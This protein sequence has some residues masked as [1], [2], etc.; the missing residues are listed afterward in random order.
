MPSAIEQAA[1]E[2]RRT[3]TADGKAEA[4]DWS[5][6]T[7]LVRELVWDLIAGCA[8]TPAAGYAYLTREFG[9]VERLLGAGR[10]RERRIRRAVA[11]HWHG[12]ADRL[13]E[14]EAAVLSAIRRRLSRLMM[15][16]LYGE[17]AEVRA[18]GA[19]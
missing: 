16:H 10:R 13:G 11:A 5:V 7:E 17:C 2:I 4:P 15:D 8:P 14:V 19:A 9:P 1:G 3:M 6:V 12:P 18:S